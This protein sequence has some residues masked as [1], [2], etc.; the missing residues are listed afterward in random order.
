LS[1]TLIVGDIHLGKGVGIGR[2]GVG[3]SLNSRVVDQLSLLDWVLD[4]AIEVNA[5]AIILTGDICQ[6]V[7][8]DYVLIELFVEWLKRCSSNYIEVHIIAGNHDLKRT[9]ARFSSYLDLITT[10]DLPDVQVH[11]N[12]NT[13]FRD[14]VGFTLVPFRDRQALG[15][16]TNEE[17]LEKIATQ[18]PYEVEGIP[19]DFSRV[20]V[21]HLALSGS[22]FVGDEFDN[23]SRE[24]M[25]PLDMF[26]GYDYVWMGHVH[27]PQV[28]QKNPYVA[29][30]G[31]LDI[32]DFGETDHTKVV[33]VFDTERKDKFY[34]I[35]VP[36]RPLRRVMVDVPD[37][38]DPTS[39]V[40]NNIEAMEKQTPFEK[41]IVRVEIKLLDEDAP[42]V[43]RD[44]ID[45]ALYDLGAFYVCPIQESRNISVVTIIQKQVIDN[46]IAP[47]TAIKVYADTQE[48]D[49]DQMK[50]R[51]ID[52]AGEY[53][54]QYYAK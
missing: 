33:V 12:T 2:P 50:Q 9:G 20:L 25:C 34:E 23:K 39:Y 51:F 14:G 37:G 21:G 13:I 17:A 3:S 24:L 44:V 1:V 10:L 41:A 48:F 40:I 49:S 8:P 46:K 36:S 19:N 11:K 30:V 45:K 28:M 42:N 43:D 4:Q 54:D 32:S 16:S 29:H 15:A 27:K 26:T 53:V 6:D 35:E 38:F 52:K 31:S 47:K 5:S 7:K 22:I 18:L